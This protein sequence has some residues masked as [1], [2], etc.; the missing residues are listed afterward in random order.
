MIKEPNDGGLHI[1]CFKQSMAHSN[2]ETL[3]AHR[4]QR[5]ATLELRH[6]ARF[7]DLSRLL[8]DQALLAAGDSLEDPASFVAR[9]NKLLL[10]LSS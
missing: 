6:E 10:E 7:G 3:D 9:L 8:F 2:S 5:S 1:V 4:P